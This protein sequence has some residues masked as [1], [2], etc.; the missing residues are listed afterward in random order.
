[1]PEVEALSGFAVAPF[2]IDQ[3]PDFYGYLPPVDGTAMHTL[4]RT[5]V[6][7]D[8]WRIRPGSMRRW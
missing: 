5:V 2:F 3:L 7:R 6:L 4:E 1:M 8:G